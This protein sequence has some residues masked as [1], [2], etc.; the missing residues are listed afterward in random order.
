MM[1]FVIMGVDIFIAESLTVSIENKLDKKSLIKIERELFTRYGLSIKQSIQQ[2][3]KLDKVLCQFL[4]TLNAQ[5][6]ERKCLKEVCEIKS[7]DDDNYTI[8]VKEQKLALVLVD[9]WFDK[10]NRTILNILLNSASSLSIPEIL[11]FYALPKTSAYEKINM[12]IKNGIL[13]EDGVFRTSTKKIVKQYQTL[14]DDLIVQS[15]I[16]GLKIQSQIR[17]KYVKTSTVIQVIHAR[18]L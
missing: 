3:H 14:F 18:S 4:G 17:K 6:L 15:N 2:F 5:D 10:D 9:S 11:S 8:I 13:V 16:N 1:M 12:F 7:D